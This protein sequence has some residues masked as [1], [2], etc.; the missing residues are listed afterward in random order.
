[1]VRESRVQLSLIELAVPVF[2]VV[3]ENAQM[4][5]LLVLG[6]TNLPSKRIGSNLQ[7]CP[8]LPISF[9]H[10]HVLAAERVELLWCQL[11]AA[12]ACQLPSHIN[13]NLVAPRLLDIH[14][15]FKSL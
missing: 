6:R 5:E 11:G 10:L 1:M 15:E 9:A 4:Q 12:G 8:Q 3:L 14:R 7:S 2:V 13:R